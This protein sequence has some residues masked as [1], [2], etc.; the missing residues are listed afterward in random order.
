MMFENL[1]ALPMYAF[2]SNDWIISIVFKWL[3]M[4][5]K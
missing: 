5:K 4:I 1:N 2:H 3:R